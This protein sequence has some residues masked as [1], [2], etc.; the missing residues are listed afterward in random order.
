M[1]TMGPRRYSSS[2]GGA[3]TGE[4][5]SIHGAVV[6]LFIAVWTTASTFPALATNRPQDP[7]RSIQ[8]SDISSYRVAESEKNAPQAGTATGMATRLAVLDQKIAGYRAKLTKSPRLYP[9]WAELGGAYLSKARLRS[10]PADQRNAERALER[11]LAIQPNAVAWRWLAAVR[12][13]QHRFPEAAALAHQ[14]VKA[15]DADGISRAVWS[16]ALLAMGRY[17]EAQAVFGDRPQDF[18]SIVGRS[19]LLFLT[20]KPQGAIAQLRQALAILGTDSSGPATD[21][22]AWCHLMIGGY[23]YEIDQP[24]EAKDAYTRALALDP[25]RIDVLEHVAEWEATYGSKETAVRMYRNI[26]A[27]VPRPQEKIALGAL[28]IDLG[29]SD[30]GRALINEAIVSWQRRL[31]LGDISVRRELALALLDHGGDARQGLKLARD[32][33]EIRHDALAY[34]TLA[35]ALYKTGAIDEAKL[36]LGRALEHGTPLRIPRQ[37]AKTIG[38]P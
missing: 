20:G 6:A 34:D 35:W 24:S 1:R 32:D 16:D 21:T 33:L 28:L 31:E 12:L 37:H 19:R 14:A 10:S 38:L 8:H 13:D 36:A 26:I 11:S 23:H 2:V 27:A 22:K 18:Y 30:K 5:R 3:T 15:W 17:D 29:F 4:D 25:D 9:V 7:S